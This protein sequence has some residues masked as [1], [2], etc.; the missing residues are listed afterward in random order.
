MKRKILFLDDDLEMMT[1]IIDYLSEYYEVS[2]CDNVDDFF[3]LLSKKEFDIFLLDINIPKIT[4]LEL[5]KQLKND[6]NFKYIPIIF[7]TAYDEIEKIEE[8]FHFG[9]DDYMVKP[10]KSK[11]LKIRIDF[12]IKNAKEQ[13]KLREVQI[14]LHNEIKELTQELAIAQNKILNEDNFQNRESRFKNT[15]GKIEKQKVAT[16]LFNKKFEEIQE[17]LEM[18]KKFL[19]NAKQLLQDT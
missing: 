13:T 16:E 14:N 9:A 6:K 18:Q 5:C 19:E 7:V 4:G 2:A 3:I 15:N 10:F 1:Y 12:H 11:E 17:K 8:G